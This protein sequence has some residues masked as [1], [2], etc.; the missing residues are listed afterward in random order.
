MESVA[1]V[2]TSRGLDWTGLDCARRVRQSLHQGEAGVRREVECTT[3][4]WEV[5]FSW[6]MMTPWSAESLLL[7]PHPSKEAFA[8]HVRCA[9]LLWQGAALCA[10]NACFLLPRTLPL[11]PIRSW[12]AESSLL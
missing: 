5:V 6:K 1:G 10:I 12:T 8:E 2:R 4:R 11:R 7:S 9:Y 3:R